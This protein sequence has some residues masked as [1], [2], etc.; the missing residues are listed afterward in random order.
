MCTLYSRGALRCELWRL[1]GPA[2]L[3]QYDRMGHH[4]APE[5]SGLF[6]VHVVYDNIIIYSVCAG[7]ATFFGR[8][9][10]GQKARRAEG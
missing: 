3:L 7:G 5:G 6:C 9:M 4:T 1:V 10:E 2:L 8:S